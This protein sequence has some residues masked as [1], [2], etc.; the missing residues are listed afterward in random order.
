MKPLS[1]LKKRIEG[2]SVRVSIYPL[3]P[4]INFFFVESRQ[5][6]ILNY[7]ITL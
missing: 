1:P 5:T 4:K 7:K 6:C 2:G 3:G